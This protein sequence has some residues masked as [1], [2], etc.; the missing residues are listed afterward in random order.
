[1]SSSDTPQEADT[2]LNRLPGSSWQSYV[3]RGLSFIKKHRWPVMN[4]ALGFTVLVA[5]FLITRGYDNVVAVLGI[6]I[7]FVGTTAAIYE[8]ANLS[9]TWRKRL[10]RFLYRRSSLSATRTDE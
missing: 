3:H 10:K 4:V 5:P 1:M 6:P 2:V 7:S 8:I 9:K